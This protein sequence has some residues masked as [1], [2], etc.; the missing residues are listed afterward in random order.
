[1][2]AQAKP[3]PQH[4]D[5]AGSHAALMRAAQRARD[6]AAETS[7]PCYVLQNDRMIDIARQQYKA[8][9]APR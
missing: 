3:L 7:T 4:P 8:P 5:V 9:V 6:L 2:N 1:M